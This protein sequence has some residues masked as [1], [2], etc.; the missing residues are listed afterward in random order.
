MNATVFRG[1]AR[2]APCRLLPLAVIAVAWLSAGAAPTLAASEAHPMV[3][4]FGSFANPNGLAADESTGDVY[5]ADIGTNAV[6]KFD[7]SGSPIDFSSLGSNVLTGAATPAGSFA[8]PNAHGNPA[9]I[10]VDNST[11]PADP[12]AG[13]L[14]VLDAGHNGGVVDKFSP[15]GAYL[16]QIVD[17]TGG[18]LLGI[19]VDGQGNLSMVNG[20]GIAVF[21]DSTTNAFLKLVTG[22]ERGLS[23]GNGGVAPEYGFATTPMGDYY[24]LWSCGCVEKFGANGEQLG[25]VDNGTNDVAAA[26]DPATGHV[27]VDEQSA[28]SE[29]DT[30]QMNGRVA[31]SAEVFETIGTG[32]H[33][34]SFGSLQ[35]SSTSGQGGIAVNGRSG[36]IYVS[37]P[38][39]GKVYVFASM[40]PGVAAGD[41]SNITKEGAR[42]QG[43]IDPNGLAVESCTFEY[44]VSRPTTLG[45]LNSSDLAA[46]VTSFGHS[47]PC[48]QTLSQIG[49]GTAAVRVSAVV[50]GLQ[51]GKLYRVRLV[52][53]NAQGVEQSSGMFASQGPGFGIK[54]FEVSFLNND[55]TPDAQAGSHPY[56][57]V[58]NI[59]FNTTVLRRERTADSLYVTVP[60]GNAKDFITDLP[61][62][63]VGDPNATATKCTLRQLESEKGDTS[64]GGD[65]PP[66]AEVGELEVEFGDGLPP[67]KEPVYNMEPPHGVAVQ[68]GGNFVIPKVFIEAGVRAGGAYQVESDSLDVPVIEPL[69]NVRL[70]VFGVVGSGATRK[71]FLTL[72]TGCT[73]PLRSS[74]SA[75]SYQNPGHFVE[76]GDITRDQAGIPVALSGCSRLSFP[77]T[78][79][80]APDT[81]NASTSSGLT[82]GVHVSQKG[83]LNPEGLAESSLRDTT[84]TLPQGVALNPAGADGLEACS[85][86]LAGFTG[87]A[88]LNSEFEP[89]VKTATFTPEMPAPLRP[90]VNFCPNGS[91]IGTVK[92][93]TP[94]LANPLEGAVYLAAPNA[95]PFGS[96][97]AMYL[98]AEDPISGTLIKLAGEVKLSATGQ[99]VTTF[100]NTPDLPFEDL[101]LH[102][103]GGER[104]PLT[105]PARCGTYT[106]TA[107]FTPWDG[108]G[109]VTSESSFTIDHGPGARPCPGGNL[110]FEPSLNAG[111]TSN[112]AGG[113]SPFTMTMSRG[114][115][116]QNLRFV[117][118]KMPEGLSGVLAG[119]KL[120][121]EGQANAGTCGPESEIGE[122]IVSVGVGNNP[123]TVE[124]GRVFLTG[125]YKGAPFG[126]SI[127]NPAKAGP[128]D[129]GQVVVRAKIEVDPRTAALT[130]TTDGDGQYKIPT[131]LQG[132]P[133]QIKHINVTVNRP[134]FTF[135]PTNCQKMQFGGE[136]YGAEGGTSAVTVPFQVADCARL[137]FKPSFNASTSGKTSRTNGASLHVTLAYPK[138]P[139]GSQANLRS[140]KVELPKQLPSR[141]PTLQ[142]AC[143]DT[144]FNTDPAACPPSSRVG[145]AKAIT[146]ILPEPL[147]GPAYFVSHGGAGWP[148]LIIVLQGYGFTI[149]LHGETFI[150]K[151]T[152]VT[153]STFPAVPDQPVTSFELTLPEGRYSALAAPG[154]KLCTTGLRMPTTFTAQ[155][156]MTIRRSTPI[157]VTG[158]KPA[159]RVLHHSTKGTKATVVVSVPSAGR[160]EAAGKGIAHVVRVLRKGGST[161]LRLTLSKTERRLL[162]KHGGRRLRVHVKL[163]FA[164]K[165]GKRLT[166]AVTLLMG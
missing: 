96:L 58:T 60:D 164:P 86:D 34:T 90:G 125:P 103:F 59:E 70:T 28:V 12:S 8:F 166:A 45:G 147:A 145:M 61:P 30:G 92:L 41:A 114:D 118:L 75:D 17:P 121:G 74:L 73:G 124:G 160:L 25:R 40:A 133:L 80:V 130:V 26:V 134:A 150:D 162:A 128:Y 81:S 7:A 11:D 131:I 100:L 151:K 44:E 127:V 63:L 78:I 93:T 33:V 141:L 76:A 77:P 158:C 101:E 142:K 37:N 154:G 42:L 18:G 36:N 108:N 51:P 107:V 144:V 126:L 137:N 102:F 109:P 91:K 143:L 146:P 156:G 153:S 20:F 67:L 140:V 23:G 79:T 110:P 68:I 120:C 32:S 95:N 119:V 116:D 112:R 115:G 47:V 113:F 97:V 15:T 21:D 16:G 84:V 13:D 136:L 111:M 117:S 83:A 39:D 27:Y 89:G 135:N 163:R 122:T 14:Y 98:I 5:V 48:E 129:L 71:A 99:I 56:D 104:A 152:G 69:I 65:C 57:M 55:G 66:E 72:P 6:Y 165:H 9:A 31:S 53:D 106:T 88:E 19:G 159:I 62:G 149:D 38:A 3:A 22:G 50:G 54:Q 4:D 123:F 105:T 52:A 157:S 87:F 161:M 85:K 138:A 94:L 139:L 49:S 35:L 10:A 1:M 29:W 132:I 82:V 2:F 46:P 43:T 24:M 148:E 64:G 155:N